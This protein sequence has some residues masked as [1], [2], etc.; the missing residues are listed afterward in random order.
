MSWTECKRCGG[1]AVDRHHIIFKSEAR[2]HL[3]L[4]NERNL[5][6][7]CRIC[8]NDMHEKKSRRGMYIKERKLWE[9]F[10]DRIRKERYD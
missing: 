8:H 4:N 5:I 10:P 7:L 2:K 3:N 9:L 6:F 1:T